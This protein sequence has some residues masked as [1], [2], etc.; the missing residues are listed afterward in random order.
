MQTVRATTAGSGSLASRDRLPPHA[1]PA[2]PSLDEAARVFPGYYFR[3]A[4][5][6]TVS[7]P[8]PRCGLPFRS[9]DHQSRPSERSSVPSRSTAKAPSHPRCPT[10]VAT[11]VVITAETRMADFAWSNRVKRPAISKRPGPARTGRAAPAAARRQRRRFAQT[12]RRRTSP[13]ACRPS[14]APPR[15][16]MQPRPR[17]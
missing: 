5:S 16:R 14:A 2:S 1:R 7:V 12:R 6:A 13:P 3:S 11:N 4:T 17:G 10:A 15:G 8:P 9:A